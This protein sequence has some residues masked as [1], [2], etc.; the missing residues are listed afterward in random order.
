M[1]ELNRLGVRIVLIVFV[2]VALALALFWGIGALI[3]ENGDGDATTPDALLAQLASDEDRVDTDQD[4]LPD[5]FENIYRTDPNNPDSDGDG[6]SDLAEL[7]TGRDPSIA[8]P[9]DSSGPPTG[10]EVLDTE[11]FTGQYLATLPINAEREDVL[12]QDRL[13]AFVELNRGQ[14]LPELS[15]TAVA[16]NTDEGKEAIEAYLNGISS[17][18]NEQIVNV[19][20]DDIE[21]GLTAQLQLNP[22]LMDEVVSNLAGNVAALTSISAP[23]EVVA[24]HTKLIQAS[25]ALHTNVIALRQIDADF[26]GGLIA[27]KNIDDLGPVFNDIAEQ[28]V[29]LETKYALE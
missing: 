21:R 17:S 9:D 11:T 22:A 27:S 2:A 4:G 24:L 18:H 6:T 26:V 25:Q 1:N 20:N 13:E 29:A 14:L 12:N 8:G 3:N 5:L 10:T 28:V 15:A 23:A 16:N 7:S 19:N